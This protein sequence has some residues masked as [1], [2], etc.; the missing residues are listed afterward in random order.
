MARYST[1]VAEHIFMKVGKFYP[2][3]NFLI[4][5]MKEDIR[6]SIILGRAF[7]VIRRAII[8]LLE[9]NLTLKIGKVKQEFNAF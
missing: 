5:E 8:D 9:G 1:G 3:A 2:F 6:M 7:L 4:L